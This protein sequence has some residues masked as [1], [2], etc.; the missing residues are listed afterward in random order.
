MIRNLCKA[1]L[2]VVP[3]EINFPFHTLEKSIQRLQG[4]MLIDKKVP[5][6]YYISYIRIREIIIVRGRL[7]V[8]AN[9]FDNLSCR[10]HLPITDFRHH[11]PIIDFKGQC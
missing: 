2:E 7:R 6:V 8:Y 1:N 11:L 5:I 9:V 10:H 4:S 3:I